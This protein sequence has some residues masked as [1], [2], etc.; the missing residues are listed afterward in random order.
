MV[1]RNRISTPFTAKRH[2][3]LRVVFIQ[4]CDDGLRFQR[5]RHD[6]QPQ[7]VSQFRTQAMRHRES[8]IEF[9]SSFV[10]FI[11]NDAGH[12]LEQRIRL[13]PPQEHPGRH[14][15][16]TSRLGFAAIH[17]NVVADRFTHRLVS[18]LR[19]PARHRTCRQTPRLDHPD[20]TRDVVVQQCLQDSRRHPSRL[21]RTRWS[22]QHHRGSVTDRRLQRR[23]NIFDWKS[24]HRDSVCSVRSARSK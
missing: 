8:Q 6:D 17:S 4:V 16:H 11:Q 18:R 12:I 23:K 20:L 10:E 24:I 21:A 14:E 5:R 9:Q 1:D 3:V 2:C 22:L 7:V 13:H 15:Q 19:D